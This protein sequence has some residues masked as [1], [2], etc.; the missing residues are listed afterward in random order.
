MDKV[1]KVAVDV[2]VQREGKLLFGKR[3]GAYGAGDWGLPGGHLEYNELLKKCAGRELLE[4]TGMT[5]RD[6]VFKGVV[7]Q[8]RLNKHYVFV[9]FLA[10]DPIGEPKVMEPDRCEEWRWLD[11]NDLPANIFAP[12]KDHIRMFLAD[13]V[14]SE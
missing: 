14:F 10:V 5:A 4:E 8:V 1:I 3:K 7:N 9:F 6:F 12:H 11:P 13:Q 2:L